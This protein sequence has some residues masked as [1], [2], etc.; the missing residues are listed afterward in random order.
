VTE[1]SVRFDRAVDYYDRTRAWPAHAH[2]RFVELAVTELA[3]RARVLE[4]GV[5]TGRVG[6]SLAAAGVDV[7]GVDLSRPML[8]RLVANAGADGPPPLAQADA[9]GLPFPDGRFGG[10]VACH[11]LHLIPGWR[12]ALAELARAVVPGG[13]VL[14]S[15]GGGLGLAGDLS[16]EVMAAAGIE[17]H[18]IPGAG[19]PEELDDGA[20]ALGLGVRVLEPVQFTWRRPP[21]QLLAAIEA[22][23]FAWTWP[24]DAEALRAA[25]AEVRERTKRR[26][27]DLD[28]P[29]GFDATISW[30]AYDVPA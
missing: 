15:R 11:V 30:R 24:L 7:V 6:L 8:E 1:A 18:G 28:R 26:W 3:G 14:A 13:V 5:G 25:V 27:G 4:I 17:G 12:H 10:A 2:A 16:K 23:Q 22:G 29:V 19:S 21:A 9:T 20:A